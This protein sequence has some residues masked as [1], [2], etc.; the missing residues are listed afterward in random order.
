[1]V[2]TDACAEGI[3]AVLM[4][5]GQPIA[6]LSKALDYSPVFSQLPV[7]T[8]IE[9]AEAVPE[10]VLNRRLERKGNTATPQ[11]QI[12]WSRLSEMATTWEDY[13]VLRQ[14]FPDA[15][16]WGQASSSAGGAVTPTA[17]KT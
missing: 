17:T 3:G 14:R 11:V 6:F 9:A 10:A 12:K 7:T 4:Q 5:K 1:M 16:A 8:D 15:P 2:E 13:N